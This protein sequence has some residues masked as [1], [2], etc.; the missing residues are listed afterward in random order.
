MSTWFN[1]AMGN[2]KIPALTPP[3]S[4]HDWYKRR[5]L[6]ADWFAAQKP[7]VM[8]TV[9]TGSPTQARWY[10]SALALKGHTMKIVLNGGKVAGF[11]RYIWRNP[12]TTSVVASGLVLLDHSYNGD[13]KECV[14]AVLTVKG[15]KALFVCGH[16]ENEGPE[17]N[18]VAQANDIVRQV[19][20]VQQAKHGINWNHTFWYMDCNSHHEVQ[21]AILA[22]PAHDM[23]NGADYRSGTG[24]KS[25]TDWRPR[26]APGRLVVAPNNLSMDVFYSGPQR[27]AVS[28]RQAD[29]YRVNNLNLT[30]HELISVKVRTL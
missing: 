10:E 14:W 21:D 6:V 13:K 17:S 18:R 27:R 2:L 5:G 20:A 24:Y 8:M 4:T 11:N 3:G 7:D 16:L 30:D 25:Q 12:A 26:T 19:I 15:R 1:I 22:G 23:K 28:Y 9:E 29:T